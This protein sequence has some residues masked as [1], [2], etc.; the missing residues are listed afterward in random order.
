M[1]LGSMGNC[2]L[3]SDGRLSILI[4]AIN[5]P[6]QDTQMRTHDRPPLHVLKFFSRSHSR[7]D[8]VPLVISI[9]AYTTE[10]IIGLDPRYGVAFKQ[11]T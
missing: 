2:L 3:V 10:G 6:P 1:L 5:S 11:V 4:L 7:S 9:I 8:F